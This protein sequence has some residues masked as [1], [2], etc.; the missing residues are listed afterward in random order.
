[1]SIYWGDR[2]FSKM[3]YPSS[4]A[5]SLKRDPTADILNRASVQRK[6]A[7]LQGNAN[8]PSTTWLLSCT[9]IDAARVGS[10]TAHYWARELAALGHEVRLMPAQYV[11][12]YSTSGGPSR[13]WTPVEVGVTAY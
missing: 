5:G 13:G 1:M 3:H 9:F 6:L 11:K 12:A 8:R 7:Y 4:N 2:L 10:A